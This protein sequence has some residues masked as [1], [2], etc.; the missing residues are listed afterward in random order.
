MCRIPEKRLVL[1]L[2]VS[3]DGSRHYDMYDRSKSTEI[4][5]RFPDFESARLRLSNATF[6][7][8]EKVR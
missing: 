8:D 2:R 1:V 5:Q 4:M 6:Y 7:V 3:K